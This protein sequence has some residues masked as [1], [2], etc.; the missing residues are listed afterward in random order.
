MD[1]TG[2]KRANLKGWYFIFL[3]KRIMGD[4]VP[5]HLLIQKRILRI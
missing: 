1:D 3:S 4:F 5:R 2:P